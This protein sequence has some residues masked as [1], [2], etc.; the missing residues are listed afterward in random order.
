MALTPEQIQILKKAKAQGMSREQAMARVFNVG[1]PQDTQQRGRFSDIGEDFLGIGEDIVAGRDQV[2]QTISDAY[3][4]QRR[5]EQTPIET[6]LQTAGALVSYPFQTAFNVAKGGMKMLTSQTEEDAVSDSL[7]KTL[8]PVTDRYNEFSPRTQRN[9]DSALNLTEPLGYGS[10]SFLKN[11]FK[12]V[13]KRVKGAS[14]A[15]DE[16]VN[17]PVSTTNDTLQQSLVPNSSQLQTPEQVFDDAASSLRQQA[18]DPNLSPRAQ[19]EAALAARTWQE[20]FINLQPDEKYRLQQMGP[21]KLQEYLDAVHTANINDMAPTPYAVGAKNVL[22]AE[23]ELLRQLSDTGSQIG[24]TRQKLASYRVGQPSIEA[25]ENSFN[26]QLNKLNLVNLNGTLRRR[27][28]AISPLSDGDIRALESLLGD[29]NTFKSNPTLTNAID[30]RKNFDAKIKFGKAARDVSNEVDPIAR[31]VRSTIADE[32]AKIVGKEQAELVTQYSNYMDALGELQSYTQ[33]RAGG[34]Y[35]LRLVQ[36]GRGQEASELI[37]TVKDF[38][39][40]D[41]MNDAS[42]MRIV[43]ERFGNDRTKNLFRQEIANAGGDV[44]ALLSGEPTTILTRIGKKLADYGIDEEDVLKAA[45]AGVG[46]YF[47]LAY[48]DTDNHLLPGAIFALSAMPTGARD[49][50]IEQAVKIKKIKLSDDD[51]RVVAEALEHYN[52]APVTVR[53]GNTTKLQFG[54]VDDDF[55]L[56]ELKTKDEAGKLTEKDLIE[57]RVLLERRGALGDDSFNSNRPE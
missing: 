38:T 56:M 34:E 11:P 31:A 10:T 22:K 27:P 12:Q 6:G 9:I 2:N 42:A 14:K 40:I 36:S 28:G 48:T 39:G 52:P 57:A 5:G 37:K 20:K 33:R 54:D 24:Q 19:E 18:S 44:A 35:L 46:G 51:K 8:Q 7:E 41:L 29:L 55:R 53:T 16:V 49:D 47:L 3:T 26:T 50:A 15:T 30:L 1:Q 21:E 25:I 23:Q 13:L 17:N 45:A 43:T 4:A 32:A